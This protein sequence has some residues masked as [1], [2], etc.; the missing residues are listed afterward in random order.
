MAS[1]RFGFLE[2]AI[3]SRRA[4]STESTES[5][6][7]A[8]G[9]VAGVVAGGLDVA[10]MESLAAVVSEADTEIVV[11]G[12]GFS[13]GVD[14]A[15]ATLLFAAGRACNDEEGETLLTWDLRAGIRAEER[16]GVTGLA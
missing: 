4:N 13:L 15:A 3:F 2:L 10:G 7:L 9:L 11:V 1:V 6:P 12:A 8:F 5:S 16:A 14:G